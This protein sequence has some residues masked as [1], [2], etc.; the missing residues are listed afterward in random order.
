VSWHRRD[1]KWS[2][3]TKFKGRREQLGYFTTELEAALAYN[4][5]C[6]RLGRPASWLNDISGDSATYA[7]NKTNARATEGAEEE[8]VQEAQKEVEEV[9]KEEEV[10]VED[11]EEGN[12]D[13]EI[14]ENADNVGDTAAGTA[15]NA[16]CATT[17]RVDAPQRP[18]R[19]DAPR[20]N[21]GAT[22]RA[23][24][25]QQ[26]THHSYPSQDERDAVAAKAGLTAAQVDHFFSIIFVNEPMSRGDDVRAL[27]T[28]K[29]AALPSAGRSEDDGWRGVGLDSGD[30]SGDNNNHPQGLEQAA[31]MPAPAPV[32]A[33]QIPEIDAA[34]TAVEAADDTTGTTAHAPATSVEPLSTVRASFGT[35]NQWMHASKHRN[36]DMIADGDVWSVSGQAGGAAAIEYE[37]L[38]NGRGD[39][40][41]GGSKYDVNGCGGGVEDDSHRR[42]SRGWGGGGGGVKRG[43]EESQ[44]PPSLSSPQRYARDLDRRI[45]L[46]DYEGG[47]EKGRKLSVP[48]DAAMA[49]VSLDANNDTDTW[50]YRDPHDTVQGGW[51]MICEPAEESFGIFKLLTPTVKSGPIP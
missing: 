21:T 47:Q 51:V 30:S 49:A 42:L 1:K 3:K 34:I 27:G 28:S 16:E 26:H 11:Q 40:G 38:G 10:E 33:F 43:R 20:S 14:K 25:S 35:D 31:S 6:R 44:S 24:G 45:S 2:A 13:G 50:L 37:E 41:D 8:E 19:S 15:A 17:L 36:K 46:L 39:I 7:H 22:G 9:K 12:D 48:P 29:I 32:T 23:C 4:T 18:Y 5:A